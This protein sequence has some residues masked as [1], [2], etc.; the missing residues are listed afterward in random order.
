MNSDSSSEAQAKDNYT[1]QHV[2][3]DMAAVQA[4]QDSA[5]DARMETMSFQMRAQV[6]MSESVA[7]MVAVDSMQNPQIQ[8]RFMKMIEGREAHEKELELEAQKR[9]EERADKAQEAEISL[10]KTALAYAFL[11]FVIL[12]IGFI[13]AVFWGASERVLLAFAIFFAAGGVAVFFRYI[14]PGRK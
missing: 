5:N 14:F 1:V 6:A 3:G 12:V 10:R 2:Q 13:A 11:I 9:E 7:T 8:E 4:D